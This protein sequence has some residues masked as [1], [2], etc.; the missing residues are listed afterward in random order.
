MSS[1]P[2]VS[3]GIGCS[4]LPHRPVLSLSKSILSGS[5][6]LQKVN[7][8]VTTLPFTSIFQTLL[9]IMTDLTQT[10]PKRPT[11]TT[12][13]LISICQHINSLGMYPKEFIQR[14]LT[15]SDSKVAKRRGSWGNQSGWVSTLEVLRGFKSVICRGKN[16]GKERWARF[17]LEEVRKVYFVFDGL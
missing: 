11:L 1:L 10:I 5:I 17:I 12:Q 6:F 9:F 16:G 15:S 14:M 3:W 4:Y 13:K 8:C 2:D 7:N